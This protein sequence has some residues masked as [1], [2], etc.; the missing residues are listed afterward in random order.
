MTTMAHE[1]YTDLLQL[2][3]YD[4]LGEAEKKELL[5]HIDRCPDC[6]R[7]LASLKR[8]NALLTDAAPAPASA[9]DEALSDARVALHAA[10]HLAVPSRLAAFLDALRDFFTPK[11]RFAF[12]GAAMAAAG[13]AAGYLLFAPPKALTPHGAA[14][15]PAAEAVLNEGD[16][17]VTNV[18][19]LNTG[20]AGGE[21]EFAFDAVRPV[22]MKGS[23]GDEKIQKILTHAMLNEQNPGVRLKSVSAIA[24]RSTPDREVKAALITALKTD[25]NPGVRKEA[26]RA[27][28]SYPFDPEV[29]AAY[30]YVL[31]HDAT[32]GLRI[33]AIN[34]LDSAA[35]AGA[36]V[37]Q[38]ILNVLKER[39]RSD[40][41]NYIRLRAKAVVDEV[42]Q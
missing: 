32:A 38:D 39:M 1:R 10:L 9:A 40:D 25:E 17:R 30:L 21:V 18:R 26:L 6:A 7:E 23:I 15:S 34:Q 28:R 4:E 8:F 22:H 13:L 16:V 41:N 29:K 42:N 14:A 20:D 12:G 19:F 5:A 24:S 36:T 33:A 27:L 35:A 37:D 11:T 2:M 31:T 3:L